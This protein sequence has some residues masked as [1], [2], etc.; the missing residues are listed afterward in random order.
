MP[1]LLK[2]VPAVREACHTWSKP[3]SK[4]R[5]DAGEL[6]RLSIPGDGNSVCVCGGSRWQAN[7]DQPCGPRQCHEKTLWCREQKVSGGIPCEAIANNKCVPPPD[8]PLLKTV[9]ETFS[10][11]EASQYIDDLATQKICGGW[12]ECAVMT[13]RWGCEM[14]V[15]IKQDGQYLRIT[16][17]GSK[18]RPQRHI[19]LLWTGAHYEVLVCR[20]EQQ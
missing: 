17:F 20:R 15:Y 5:F 8:G 10:D 6:R 19:D 3:A 13:I 11:F 14:S 2:E 18:K 7:V 9:I 4:K 1:T 12:P 16:T